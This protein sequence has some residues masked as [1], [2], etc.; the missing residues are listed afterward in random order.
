M[1]KGVRINKMAGKPVKF[2]KLKWSVV[3]IIKTKEKP[4]NFGKLKEKKIG[5]ANNLTQYFCQNLK[6]IGILKSG[7]NLS[8]ENH[9][10]SPIFKK[11]S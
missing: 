10:K 4:F 11:I 2:K 9:K 6:N 8:L 5:L 3:R 7:K 1:K